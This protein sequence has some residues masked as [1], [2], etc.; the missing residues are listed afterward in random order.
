MLAIQVDKR[1][2][3]DEVLEMY[4]NDVPYG[5]TAIGVEAASETYF[6][7]KVNELNLA[8]S[9]LLAG[10]PQS[11]SLYSPFAGNKYY[12]GRSQQ[13]LKNMREE[14]YI[15]KDEEEKA[16]SE[17]KEMKF[18]QRDDVSMKAP[19]FVIYVK[20]I[21]ASQFGEA[22]VET[23]GLQ[24]KT[25][26]D[27][28]LQ[29]KAEDIVREEIDKLKGFRVGN[30]AAIVADP[31]TGEI[32]A[33]VGSKDYFDEKGDGN[34]NVALAARQPGSSLKPIVYATAFKR[35]YTPDTILWDVKTEFNQ[36]C[37]PNG[38][39]ETDQYDF[40]CRRIREVGRRIY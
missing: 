10:L 24:V 38:I 31:K 19:H 4:L 6:G 2:S 8:E 25:T 11:P 18:T 30:G 5:G 33:M 35:G 7:K 12:I 26:L 14:K 13:V 9:A 40:Y 16:L 27:Y 36:N 15:T 29:K 32:L 39:K 21:L 23:G 3:K 22:A 17:V 20:Q 34:F 1:Y 28:E 37:N